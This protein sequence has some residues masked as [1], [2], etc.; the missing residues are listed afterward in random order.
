MPRHGTAT[1]PTK[2][3]EAVTKGFLARSARLLSALRQTTL[4]LHRPLR[5]PCPRRSSLFQLAGAAQAPLRAPRPASAFTAAP[6]TTWPNPS[7]NA[8]PN[9]WPALPCPAPHRLS[10]QSVQARPPVGPALIQT[11]GH[12]K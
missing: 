12:T 3:G 2:T 11:L 1:I 4:P 5:S 9:G 7:F 8:S 6:F 10:S